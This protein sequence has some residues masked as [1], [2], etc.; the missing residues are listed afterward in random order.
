MIKAELSVVLRS[1]FDVTLHHLSQLNLA[2]STILV[3]RDNKLA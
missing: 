1:G 3:S 2:V